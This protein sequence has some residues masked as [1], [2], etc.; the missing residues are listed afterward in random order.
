MEEQGRGGEGLGSED[1]EVVRI[2]SAHEF[3]GGFAPVFC[4]KWMQ[5]SV[6]M[7]I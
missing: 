7:I 5:Y 6:E 2:G 3:A 4:E 1:G